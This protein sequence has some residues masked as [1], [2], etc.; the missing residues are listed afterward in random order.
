M[1]NQKRQMFLIK[2]PYW[3]GIGADALWAVLLFFPSI[4]GN[5]MGITDYNPDFQIKQIMGVG[6]VLMT[7]WT[8][9]LLWAVKKPI[10]RR[11]VIFLT[12]F[13]VVFGLI[14]IVLRNISVGNTLPVW[15]LV[16][17]IIL[18]ITMLTSYFLSGKKVVLG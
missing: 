7:G 12:A 6:G 18:F 2:L 17:T 8:F 1:K 3:L 15:I 11:F 16:K 4:Y 13:P 10:E 5:L 14:L 9:L